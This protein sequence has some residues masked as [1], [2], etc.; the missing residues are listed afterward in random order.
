MAEPALSASGLPRPDVSHLVTEDGEPVDGTFS[1]RQMRLLVEPLYSSWPEGRPFVALA[2]VGLF[3]SLREPPVVPDVLLS[4]GV[5]APE[6]PFSKENRSYLVWEYGKPPDV[7]I[8]V[9]SNREGGEESKLE[10]YALIGVPYCAIY[11]PERHL[12]ERPLR[13]FERH[14]KSFVELL[15]KA[16]EGSFHWLSEICLGL[17]LWEGRY[18]DVPGTWLRWTTLDGMLI[19]T[20]EERAE[21]AEE[22]AEVAEERAE[23]AEE[24]AEM[25]EER[26]NRLAARLKQLG[27]EE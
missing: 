9:V 8:E 21:V 20:G 22:R 4:L 24:R 15:P 19:P 13:V 7:A 6:D 27:L 11:D 12:S 26:A 23:V 10:K 3:F 5:T 2:N 18:E 1:E 14:A 17:K 25:A 16:R